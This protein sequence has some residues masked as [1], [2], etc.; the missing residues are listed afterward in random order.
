MTRVEVGVGVRTCCQRFARLDRGPGEPAARPILCDAVQE[1][2]LGR[3]TPGPA[4]PQAR[5]QRLHG[6]RGAVRGLGLDA[7]VYDY[8]VSPPVHNMHH[9]PGVHTARGAPHRS[10]GDTTRVKTGPRRGSLE[11]NRAEKA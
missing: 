6:S 10:S 5:G 2:E 7:P 4:L 1:P 11:M 9:H 3:R 8:L